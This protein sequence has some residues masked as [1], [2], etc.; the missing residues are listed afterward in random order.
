MRVFLTGAT[1]FIGARIVPRLIAA[2]HE[3]LG[4]ARSEAAARD[5]EA[6]G[7][8]AHRGTLEDA[9]SIAAGAAAADATIH[10][11][12]DHDFSRF[13]ES[14]EKDGRVIA[15]MAQALAGSG[16]PLIV[17][18]GVH[19]GH[20]R[21]GEP[22]IESAV[23]WNHPNPRI[24]TERAAAE[25]A[26]AG[27]SVAVVRLPQVHDP[28]KQGLISPYVDLCRTTGVA[29]YVGD[30]ANRWSAAHVDDVA[31]LYVLALDRHEPG[32]RYHAVAEE[33]VPMRAI[34]E[35]VARGLGIPARSI[36]PA[37]VPAQFGWLALFAGADMTASSA[38]T[39]ATLGWEPTGPDLLTD[40][41]AM[42]YG[43][44]GPGENA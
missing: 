43:M 44:A 32:A 14:C 28:V 39:R 35:T 4:L 8:R 24:R 17:T 11:A 22:A 38:W 29:A 37:E 5:L 25:A 10:T 27:V 42:D 9:A 19:L 31:R 26:G 33:G 41:R 7:A 18:S 13:P 15:A 6:A 34:A 3:V 23:D 16:K 40:L 30:G 12:F 21:D 36:D 2:G 1:G 20:V